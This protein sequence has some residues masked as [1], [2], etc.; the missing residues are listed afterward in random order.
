MSSSSDRRAWRGIVCAFSALLLWAAVTA[1]GG[2][3][4]L[5]T[6]G[7]FKTDPVFL[8]RA[9]Q[10]V[11][12][13]VQERPTQLRLMRLNLAA[14]TREP[15]HPEEETRSE[16]EPGF[17]ADGTRSAFV[18]NEGNLSLV[19]VIRDGD[20][21]EA[22]VKAEG[23]FDGPHSP[24]FTPDGTRVVYA[25]PES[26]RQPILSINLAAADRKVVIDSAGVNNWPSVSPDGR[27][28]AFAST[29]D[30]DY[31]IYVAEIDGSH[32]RRLTQSP[33]M[34]VRPRFSPDGGRI[35]FTSN[36]D[37]N[38]EIY[39]TN[40]DGSDLTR[41]TRN[42]ERDDY[43]SWHPDGRHLVAVCERSGRFDVYLLD[44]PSQSP[45]S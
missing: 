34:D 38:Y 14:R 28:L 3:Q 21:H 12:Y 7:R 8:G 22:L 27:Q 39:L 23:G 44:V 42:D 6:D 13:T 11:V 19:L 16:F 26:A 20:G 9:G 4:R 40:A 29:R 5:T 15:L 33:R 30:G 32:P 10:A 35:A 41:V 37:G 2:E 43:P 24:T 17:S 45:G 18:R 36:R 1:L 31:E 25:H